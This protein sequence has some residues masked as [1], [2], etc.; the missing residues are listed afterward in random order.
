LTAALAVASTTATAAATFT[1][2]AD[3]Y[4]DSGTTACH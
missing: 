3:T 4:T 2:V 1:A